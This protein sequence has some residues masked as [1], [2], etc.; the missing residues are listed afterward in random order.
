MKTFKA[1][2][3]IGILLVGM[4]LSSVA[5]ETSSS[6]KKN[7]DEMI[8][9]AIWL[10]Q[11]NTAKVEGL[12]RAG[13]DPNT[14]Y[15]QHNTSITTVNGKEV[16]KESRVVEYIILM[17]MRNYAGTDEEISILDLLLEYKADPNVKNHWRR[18][19]LG[20]AVDKRFKFKDRLGVV[21]TLLKAGAN[22]NQTYKSD[23]TTAFSMLIRYGKFENKFP[24][25]EAMLE[26]GADPGIKDKYGNQLLASRMA[27]DN[28]RLSTEQWVKILTLMKRFGAD[29]NQT[30][31]GS[32]MLFSTVHKGNIPLQDYLIQNGA[33]INGRDKLGRTALIAIDYR[34]KKIKPIETQVRFLLD[35]GL[36]INA[37]D[38]SGKS[39]L[40][41]VAANCKSGLPMV[42]LLLKMG[43]QL[44]AGNK[45]GLTA[46]GMAKLSR[47]TSNYKYLVKRGG[48]QYN[49]GPAVKNN[50]AAVTA[51]FKKD[52]KALAAM[53]VKQLQ[54]LMARSKYGLA[55]TPLHVAVET[56]DMDIIKALGQREV[57]WNV[58]DVYEST[59]LHTAILE[60]HNDI[61]LY[62]MSQKADPNRDN[63]SGETAYSYAYVKD[64]AL[65]KQMKREGAKP[66]GLIHKAIVHNDMALLK[67]LM[68]DAEL[69]PAVLQT[70]VFSGNVEITRYLV[71]KVKH[72]EKTS[73]EIIEAAEQ[74]RKAIN[75]FNKNASSIKKPP[76]SHAGIAKKRGDFSYL[77]PSWSPYD[78]RIPRRNLK[79]FALY[80]HVPKHYDAKKPFGLMVF[81]HGRLGAKEGVAGNKRRRPGYPNRA[82]KKILEKKNII[83]VGYSAYNGIYNDQPTLKESK[84]GD[85]Y[86]EAFNLAIVYE[87]MK[88]FN[89]N[90]NRVYLSGLS[91]GG[92]LT[93]ENFSHRP[94]IFKGGISIGGCANYKDVLPGLEYIQKQGTIVTTSGEFDY[95][96]NETYHGFNYFHGLGVN[97]HVIQQ[98]RTGHTYLSG[99]Y[100]KRALDVLEKDRTQK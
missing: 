98:P 33:D 70:A 1:F 52:L 36:D 32:P 29:L 60:G 3:L 45:L 79:D 64:I 54:A 50:T 59:P 55:V 93:C 37:L 7:S 63:W 6:Q 39:I 17:A 11:K 84:L 9:M 20:M 21:N 25:L 100:F 80:V 91:W 31:F 28:G 97:A 81:M 74:S 56:G 87:M 15:Y 12:L 13:L 48:T 10:F 40:T 18:I 5:K 65:F 14:P 46:T 90:E 42:K 8:S 43:A 57:N 75:A 19:P 89:I 78:Q 71:E 82:Y 83:W 73:E 76:R 16:R 4:P 92:R 86:H 95:N 44:N 27:H 69:K 67:E 68:T 47:C 85:F 2:W 58:L 66:R 51:I 30:Y 24:M 61:A 34:N 77:L 53:P 22:P 23:S 49:G 35:K 41:T 99:P 94:D 38:D 72:P 62:L 88:H 26:Y 96:A